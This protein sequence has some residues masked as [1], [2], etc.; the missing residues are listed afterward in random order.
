[1]CVYIYIHIYI[2]LSLC[3]YIYIYIYT[4]TYTHTQFTKYY[5]GPRAGRAATEMP[6]VAAAGAQRPNHT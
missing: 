5:S 4:Y 3:V 2:S 6:A 1:M